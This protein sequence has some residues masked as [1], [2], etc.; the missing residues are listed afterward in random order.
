MTGASAPPTGLSSLRDEAATASSPKAS[1]PCAF[2]PGPWAAFRRESG[3]VAGYY[4]DTALGVDS[5]NNYVIAD[6]IVGRHAEANAHLIAAAPEL[7]EDGDDAARGLDETADAIEN[8][9]P[10]YAEGMR[11]MAQRLRANRAKARGETGGAFVA[12]GAR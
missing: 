2:T 4:I 11:A 6:N 12:G 10:I 5:D 1:I 3:K 9:F 8:V 7:Y